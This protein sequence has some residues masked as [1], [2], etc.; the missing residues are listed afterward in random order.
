MPDL[1][2]GSRRNSP[3]RPWRAGAFALAMIGVTGIVAW[4]IFRRSVA[5]DVPPGD[6]HGDLA[7]AQTAPGT[8]PRLTYNTSSL[9]WVGGIPVARL[10]GDAHAIG[11]AHGRLLATLIP[12][13]V[14]AH[15][16]SIEATVSD[17]GLFGGSTHN[18][19][20]SWRWRFVDDGMAEADRR[21]VAGMWRGAS[22]SGIDASFDD[23]LRDQAVL[24]V[25]APSPRSA[26]TETHSI[27]HSLT[28]VVPQAQSSSR[29]WIARS[30]ALTGLDDGGEAERPVL[31]IA[32]PE[33]HLAWAAVTWPGELGVVTGVNANGLAVFVNP[34]RSSEVRTT[35]TARPVAMLARAVLEQSSTID[36]AVKQIEATPTLGAAVIVLV[37]GNTGKWVVVERTPVKAIVERNPKSPALGDLL[38]TNALASDPDNDRA[39]RVLGTLSRVERATRLVKQPLADVGAVATVL[40]DAR[41]VDDGPRPPGH[42][43]VID[44]GRAGQ[45]VILDPTTLELWIA[46]P[47]SGGRMRGFDLRHELRGEGDHATPPPDIAVDPSVDGDRAA[48]L[49]AARADLRA[50]RAALAAGDKDLAAEACARARTHAPVLP[51]ALELEAMIA[52]ARGDDARARQLWQVWLD[53]GADD[54]PGE[55]R[56]RAALQ[57]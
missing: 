20:V 44:D 26:E 51:E 15:K 28:V 38:T 23:L 13:V 39:R 11:A 22:A 17:D 54:P 14:A 16:P 29:V 32:H 57:H 12:P 40:R 55:E 31:E 3:P 36:E 53:A 52:Q 33:G 9:S 2:I 43:G 47:T 49:V 4:F 10:A 27:A 50:A 46:D 35:R 18:M 48:A 37:D 34:S 24:D 8:E 45:V 41:G 21:M 42:R 6:V 5:Y 1:V 56:A 19:R 30:F 7:Y 25:G